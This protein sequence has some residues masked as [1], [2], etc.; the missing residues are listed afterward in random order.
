MNA[1]IN[2]IDY[3]VIEWK[4]IDDSGVSSITMPGNLRDIVEICSN[5][6]DIQLF[7]DEDELIGK[8]YIVEFI[9]AEKKDEGIKASFKLS[10]IV[11][12]REY[13]IEKSVTD[14]EDILLEVANMVAEI[15]T[16]EENNEE[17]V[18][19]Y[20]KRVEDTI[21]SFESISNHFN[22]RVNEQTAMIS[23]VQNLLNELQNNLV[24]AQNAIA[25]MP[26][27]VNERFY[28]LENSYNALADRVAMLEN[29][30]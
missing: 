26:Q 20:K 7:S 21:Q 12:T 15:G 18:N 24:A 3:Q 16:L 13:Q 9:S 14:A 25:T 1:K 11:S 4:P 8:Y 29:R 23:Q 2:N 30:G 5:A 6:T 27:N 17:Y 10:T 28:A 19:Q 22:D